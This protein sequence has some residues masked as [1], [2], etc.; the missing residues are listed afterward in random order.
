M[1]IQI[2]NRIVF[3]I[4]KEY[5]AYSMSMKNYIVKERMLKAPAYNT[6]PENTTTIEEIR[7][8]YLLCCITMEFVFL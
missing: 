8:L 5:L 3:P 6:S 1:G 7:G 4:S 2:D